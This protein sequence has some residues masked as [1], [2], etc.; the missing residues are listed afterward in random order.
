MLSM[1]MLSSGWSKKKM[2]NSKFSSTKTLCDQLTTWVVRFKVVGFPSSSWTFN[3]LLNDHSCNGCLPLLGAEK[4][5]QVRSLLM[6]WKSTNAWYVP[7]VECQK[8]L[9][10]FVSVLVHNIW[11]SKPYSV[12]VFKHHNTYFHTLFHPHVF[13]QNLNKVSKKHKTCIY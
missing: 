13:L 6:A 4:D 11:S 10:E 3:I 12:T 8:K 1:K 9:L 2:R 7:K 5:K